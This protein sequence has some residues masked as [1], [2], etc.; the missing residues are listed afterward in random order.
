[1]TK[2][3]FDK[4]LPL[5]LLFVIG[6]TLIYVGENYFFSLQK[7]SI[8]NAKKEE[9]VSIANLKINELS[10][11]YAEEIYDAQILA[12]KNTLQLFIKN[13]KDKTN[14]IL[15]KQFTAELTQ[16]KKEHDYELITIFTPDFKKYITT[17]P[18]LFS[19]DDSLTL[20]LCKKVL[21]RKKTIS[22]DLYIN[23]FDNA[24]TI[25]FIS[26]VLDENNVPYAVA[27]FRHD[28]ERFLFPFIEGWPVHSKT[29]E[30][31]IFRTESDQV[32]FLNHLRYMPDAALKL[33]IP[34]T[35]DKLPAVYAAK[36]HVGFFEGDDYRNKH[37][38]SYVDS[39]PGTQ[40]YI[41]AKI[42]QDE[43]FPSIFHHTIY[44]NII[45]LISAIILLMLIYIIFITQKKNNYRNLYK[46]RQE[47]KTTFYSIGDAVIITSNTGN[48][49]NMNPVAEKLTGWSE[50]EATGKPI[51]DIFFLLNEETGEKTENPV[52]K[53][54]EK[55]IVVGLANHSVLISKDGAQIP[56]SDSGAPIFDETGN[57]SGIVL[58][59]RDQIN[60]RKQQKYLVETKRKMSTLLSNLPG[61]AYRCLNNRCWTMEFVSKGCWE[62]TGYHY[63]EIE[64][65]EVINYGEL[66]FVDDQQMVWNE[67][68]AALDEKKE[69]QLEYRIIT[70]NG[71][72]KWVWEKGRGVFDDNGE[73]IAIEGFINDINDRITTEVAL[74]ASE[75]LFQTLAQNATVGIFRTNENGDTVYVNKAWC[76]LTEMD[77]NSAYGSG[78][79]NQVHPDD[80]ESLTKEWNRANIVQEISK[81]EYRFIHSDGSIVWVKGQATPEFS[82]DGNLLGYI[83]TITDI[84]EN[85]LASEILK[86]TNILLRT[87]IDNIP[88]AVYMKDLDGKKV[89]ANKA[90]VK[91]CGA[92]FEEEIIG[93]TDFEMFPNEIA[94]G[95][96]KDDQQVLKS[97]VPVIN[98]EERLINN[99]DEQKWLL[100]SKIPFKDKNGKLIGLIGIG[101]D[102]T[103]MKRDEEEM[104]KLTK[105]IAQAPV[106]IVITNPLG[107]I[108]YVNPKFS[109]T[110]GYTFEETMG[111]N[112]R[113]LKS[114]YQ[115]KL[116]YTNLWHTIL[117]GKDWHGELLN[118]KKDGELYWE[119]AIISPILN[120]NGE[121][122]YFV[123]VNEDIT[124]KKKILE[125]LINA[126]E[127]AEE[128]DR[129]K[130][131]FLANMSHEIR[132]PLNSIL[133]FSNF[134]TGEFDLTD[135]EKQEY[136]GII[137]RSADSLLQII[138]D[139]IDISS[140]ETGQ[141]KTFIKPLAVN[142]ILK[143]LYL[144]FS[145]KLD[146][147][148]KS[149]IILTLENSEP[150]SVMADENRLVQVFTNLLNNSAKFTTRGEI[151]F[152]IEKMD[153]KKVVFF[154]SDTGIGIAPEMHNTVFERFRQVE[155]EKNR[156][157]GGNG[158]GLAIVK[159]LIELMGGKIWLKSEPGKG[160]TFRFW[161]KKVDNDKL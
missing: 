13:W 161:L 109:E 70:R 108:E 151:R 146:E 159:N 29:A 49:R 107:K 95:F 100:T 53:V 48:I 69:F 77:P 127:R 33:R 57:I 96:W 56:V 143:S 64:N 60:E 62:L 138:N 153:R 135:E 51:E 18:E 47:F 120:E 52:R 80:R 78:W 73:I 140:L 39:V 54:I 34:F 92:E 21:Y 93:K 88:D 19:P 2:K 142:E 147:L 132:T 158:L 50:Q 42:D 11:W 157:F 63:W 137:N 128:S 14:T 118:K 81:A 99:P 98:R 126:K 105:A 71:N 36:G 155:Q 91:N 123:A 8:I 76:E 26:P 68:Q 102:I 124:E 59:F 32:L 110:T 117:A 6:L 97:G 17:N 148:N 20:S 160:S 139:I 45:F 84:T 111:K 28:P 86:N 16:I 85:K 10:D 61:M 75:H 9:L 1:M 58:V 101:H 103:R 7:K 74:K 27:I 12:A 23:Q 116:F 31:L 121:I 112:P 104:L 41:V 152:G 154:V 82:E 115:S 106:S 35:N 24:I 30:T 131:S 37:V 55:G 114:G 67:V 40:W 44:Q 83:G 66:I 4:I 90:D 79:L 150:V 134:L 15:T 133:G 156:T 38:L 130:S 141:L 129:L 119:N 145:K 144:V 125:E 5:I 22:S 87:I 113:I 89:L 46:S 72:I 94:A 65:N 43:I 3:R 25:D 136:N 149:H 122:I